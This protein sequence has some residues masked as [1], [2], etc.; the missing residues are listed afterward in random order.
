MPNEAHNKS[1]VQPSAKKSD[2]AT[3][4]HQSNSGQRQPTEPTEKSDMHSKD[5]VQ[6]SHRDPAKTK[7]TAK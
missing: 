5:A 3:D 6:S 4:K 2:L 7:S 1:P